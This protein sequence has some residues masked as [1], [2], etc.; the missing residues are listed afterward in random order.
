MMKGFGASIPHL[1]DGN[2]RR[3]PAHARRTTASSDRMP[4]RRPP[5]LQIDTQI[6][7][8]SGDLVA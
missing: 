1:G 6:A 7:R 3:Y 2:L 8:L 4:L 5:A